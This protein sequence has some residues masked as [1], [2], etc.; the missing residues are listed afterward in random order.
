MRM[1]QHGGEDVGPYRIPQGCYESEEQKQN[2]I[3]D[4]EDVTDDL[5][6][7]AVVRQLMQEYGDYTGGHGDDEPS[8]TNVRDLMTLPDLG[9]L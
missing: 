9:S 1:P 2:K 8:A 3:E 6:P 4:E 5:K 7:V